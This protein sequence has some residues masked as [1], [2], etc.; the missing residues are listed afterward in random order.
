LTREDASA[1]LGAAGG[2]LKVAILMHAQG[3]SRDD[4]VSRLKRADGVLRAALDLGK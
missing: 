1:L 4:A 2:R 3:L